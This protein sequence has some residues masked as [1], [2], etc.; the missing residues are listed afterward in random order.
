LDVEFLTQMMALRHGHAH[1]ELRRRRTI[2]LISALSRCALL[3]D[4]EAARLMADY[5]FL[6]R[7]ENRLRIEDDQ[8]ASAM[9]T[10]PAALRP[11]ARRMGYEGAD[12]AEG[13]LAEVVACRNRIREVFIRR[14]AAERA[15][16]P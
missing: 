2:E 16:A 14:F 13:L 12:A 3:P 15:A 4:A 6:S 7:L 8:P 5:R 11:L 10:E 9:P 1:P